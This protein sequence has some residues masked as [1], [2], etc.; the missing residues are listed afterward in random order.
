[1]AWSRIH[2]N[3]LFIRVL[4]FN[5]T[6]SFDHFFLSH[7]LFSLVTK[8]TAAKVDFRFCRPRTKPDIPPS[9]SVCKQ[10]FGPVDHVQLR[11]DLKRELKK[12]TGEQNH[13]W[14]FDFGKGTPLPGRYCWQKVL[15]NEKSDSSSAY[16]NSCEASA[17]TGDIS[18]CSSNVVASSNAGSQMEEKTIETHSKPRVIS[19]K[20]TSSGKMTG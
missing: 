9:L 16:L 17:R 6:Q 3:S 20:R 13:R 5:T 1:M 18:A 4:R 10:L 19:R 15:T 7:Q 14:N 2:T 11:A 8:M 12:L